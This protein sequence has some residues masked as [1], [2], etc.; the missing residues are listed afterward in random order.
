MKEIKG[1]VRYE[2]LDV[3]YSNSNYFVINLLFKEWQ[4][5]KWLEVCI[6][7][8]IVIQKKKEISK[9]CALRMKRLRGIISYLH[10]S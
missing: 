9:L 4:A 1:E 5:I 7:Q 10:S 8:S 6:F 3:E 2:T